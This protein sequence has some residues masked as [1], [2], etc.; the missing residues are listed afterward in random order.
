MFSVIPLEKH[1]FRLI[2]DYYNHR[3]QALQILHP[4]FANRAG[5]VLFFTNW[6][7][8]CQDTKTSWFALGIVRGQVHHPIPPYFR[9][10]IQRCHGIQRF[11]ELKYVRTDGVVVDTPRHDEHVDQHALVQ[12]ACQAVGLGGCCRNIPRPEC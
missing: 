10:S 5:W 2:T 1:N 12:L 6:C 4:D 11:P 3:N 8:N 7:P 9:K